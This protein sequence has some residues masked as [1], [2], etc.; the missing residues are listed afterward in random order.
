MWTAL[1]LIVFSLFVMGMPFY[2]GENNNK[3]E[4]FIATMGAISFCFG[5]PIITI[6]YA[7][8]LIKF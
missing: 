2:Q 5:F 4:E 8:N 6:A 3:F 1:Y 7:I